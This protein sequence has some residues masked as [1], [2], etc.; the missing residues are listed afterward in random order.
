MTKPVSLALQGGGSHGAYTWGVL[1]VLLESGLFEI[2]AASGTSAGALNAAALVQGLE[3][4][5]DC[6][7][8]QMAYLWSEIGRRSPLVPF[9]LG[10]MADTQAFQPWLATLRLVG[11]FASPYLASLNSGELLE[12]IIRSSIDFEALEKSKV[13]LF[14]CATDV[15]NGRARIFQDLEIDTRS[16]LASACLPDLF[17]AVKIEGRFYWDGGYSSNPPIR[18]L[19]NDADAPRDILIIQ[20]TPF[21]RNGNPS[22][23]L[24]IMNR[25]SEITFNASL[26]SA[27]ENFNNEFLQ[28]RFSDKSASLGQSYTRLHMIPAHGALSTL[29][30]ESKLDTRPVHLEELRNLGKEAAKLWLE[31]GHHILFGKNSSIDIPKLLETKF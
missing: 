23:P 28:N 31:A 4:N 13:R 19:I 27:L 2:K 12:A 3:E 22:T 21:V 30:A 6:P 17:P 25:A 8:A 20:V 16:L 10:M 9:D 11:Q 14:V 7:D 5:P 29:P 1:E 15:A 24:Q 26:L 18:P